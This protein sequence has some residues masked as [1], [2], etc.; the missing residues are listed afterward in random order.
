MLDR[1]NKADNEATLTNA[2][3]DQGDD[4]QDLGRNAVCCYGHIA[5]LCHLAVGDHLRNAHQ[6]ASQRCRNADR[7]HPAAYFILHAEILQTNAQRGASAPKI[8][9]IIQRTYDVAD[10]CGDR[11]T[12][13]PP[14]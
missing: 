3:T 2:N 14:I 12:C 10:H 13:D 7:Q 4:H 9:Q 6:Q 1:V 8:D 5:V 11:S